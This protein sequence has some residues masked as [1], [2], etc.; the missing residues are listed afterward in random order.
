M[1]ASSDRPLSHRLQFRV[2]IQLMVVLAV[3]LTVYTLLERF[4]D[5]NLGLRIGEHIVAIAVVGLATWYVVGR[6]TKPVADME[7]IGR[8]ISQVDLR[9]LSGGLARAARGDFNASLT[10]TTEPRLPDASGE[11]GDLAT[12]LNSMVEEL[13]DCGQAY[14]SMCNDLGSLVAQLSGS[15][16][17]VKGASLELSDSALEAGQAILDITGSIEE[18]AERAAQETGE[19]EAA[20]QAVRELTSSVNAVTAGTSEMTTAIRQVAENAEAV[21]HAS[22][23]ANQAARDGGKRVTQ[24]IGRMNTFKESFARAMESIQDLG[25]HSHEIGSVVAT[26]NDIA[27]QTTVLALNA[28]IEASRAG[29]QGK[30]FGI[31]AA[32]VRKLAE[33]SSKAT[34]EIETLILRVQSGISDAVA[35]MEQGSAEVDQGAQE[36]V[37]ADNALD[38]IVKAVRATNNQIQ[39]IS[40]AAE[41]MT[42]QGETTVEAM[43]RVEKQAGVVAETVSSISSLARA[44][45]QTNAAVTDMA[46]EMRARIDSITSAVR[47]MA[48]VVEHLDAKM[49][50]FGSDASPAPAAAKPAN[51]NGRSAN[52]DELLSRIKPTLAGRA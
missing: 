45:A 21:E 40:A 15:A 27:E 41:E 6:V 36:A 48:D 50:Q 30:S 43:R 24:T 22:D 28:A 44:N 23:L 4:V 25:K 12:A 33:R 10:V 51:G 29:E 18:L 32:E 17:S 52:L 2:A 42:A 49:S 37:N 47:G 1:P 35:V 3:V 14:A 11:L 16:Q 39:G 5:G 13:R 31:V 8:N 38:E 7:A 19:L 34:K 20:A 46:R 26:I 9:Q